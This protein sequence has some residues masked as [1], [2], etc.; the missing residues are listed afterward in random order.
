[1]QTRNA[2]DAKS[3]RRTLSAAAVGLLLL[4][5]PA[6]AEIQR[7]TSKACPLRFDQPTT[8]LQRTCLF[9]GRFSTGSGE[10]MAAFAGDG[11]AVVVAIA[12]GDA[13]P[14]LFL[15]AAVEGPTRGT[16]QRWQADVEPGSAGTVTL[17]D[18]GRRLRLRA[19][20]P[21]GQAGPPAEFVGYFADMV[22]AGETVA[23]Y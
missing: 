5:A 19:T 13:K 4:A 8:G 10:L 17:E 11:S 21:E 23:S 1:M 3:R 16:L 2:P 7:A 14:L 15:P 12:R 6:A 9:V 18:G 20:L 22:D